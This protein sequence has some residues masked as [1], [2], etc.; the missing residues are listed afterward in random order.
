MHRGRGRVVLAVSANGGYQDRGI[1]YGPASIG[2]HR[3]SNPSHPRPVPSRA[4]SCRANRLRSPRGGWPL[5]PPQ[6]PAKGWLVAP[7]GDGMSSR[8]I[9]LV[10]LDQPEGLFV[11]PLAGSA[12]DHFAVP[13][14]AGDAVDDPKAAHPEAAQSLQLL[15]QW[16]ACAGIFQ[17]PAQGCM[18]LFFR[19]GCRPRMRSA[20]S[21]GRR[22]LRGGELIPGSRLRAELR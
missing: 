3:G 14:S 1:A 4:P 21:W 19:W 12:C 16:L 9:F 8:S 2:E 22:S 15:P 5:H 13:G 17:D 7:R 10:A 6:P 18:D 20:T 11:D